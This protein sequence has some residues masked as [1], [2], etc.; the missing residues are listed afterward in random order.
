MPR[1]YSCKNK[2]EYIIDELYK[3]YPLIKY[4]KNNY[5]N[6]D[7]IKLQSEIELEKKGFY[8][9]YDEMNYETVNNIIIQISDKITEKDI[10]YDLGSG[11]GKLIK[12]FYFNTICQKLVG[13]EY[14]NILYNISLTIKNKVNI[15]N[16]KEICYYQKN[17]CEA[18]INEATIIYF[19]IINN[20]GANPTE[21]DI[22]INNIIT[23][24]KKSKNIRIVISLCPLYIHYKEYRVI[25]CV[26]D[27]VG[28][29]IRKSKNYPYNHYFY[30][31]R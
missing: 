12:Q 25:Q 28:G 17:I 13:I 31:I 10:F 26:P 20:K 23:K 9:N 6:K 19:G 5:Y 30:F 14:N 7:Y 24:I 27:M 3:D 15:E 8:D 29:R 21:D 11:L 16:G 4:R 18:D 22:L 1:I 2:V